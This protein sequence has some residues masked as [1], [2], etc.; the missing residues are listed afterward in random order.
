MPEGEQKSIAEDALSA[1]EGVASKT[2]RALDTVSDEGDSGL[3]LSDLITGRPKAE[4]STFQRYVLDPLDMPQKWLVRKPL[5]AIAGLPEGS[6]ETLTTFN[7]ALDRPQGRGAVLLGKLRGD[8]ATPFTAPLKAIGKAVEAVTGERPEAID[9]LSQEIEHQVTGLA[10]PLMLV[11]GSSGPKTALAVSER[12]LRSTPVASKATA[13]RE[14]AQAISSPKGLAGPLEASWRGVKKALVKAG[15]PISDIEKAFGQRGEFFGRGQLTIADKEI[16]PALGLGEFAGGKLAQK[17]FSKL[18][19]TGAYGRLA[20]RVAIP[21]EPLYQALKRRADTKAILST[22]R[23]TAERARR[24]GMATA[25]AAAKQGLL[26]PNAV[27]DIVANI[28]DNSQRKGFA[29][30]QARLKQT[31]T[32]RGG[33]LPQ[34]VDQ[35]LHATWQQYT[36]ALESVARRRATGG[37]KPIGQAAAD[38]ATKAI[39]WV[40]SKWKKNILANTPGYHVVNTWGDSHM[41]FVNG[42]NPLGIVEADRLLARAKGGDWK[43][44][45]ELMEANRYGIGGVQPPGVRLERLGGHSR[46]RDERALEIVGGRATTGEKASGAIDKVRGVLPQ[47]LPIGETYSDWW[48]SVSKLA[49]YIDGKK[50]GLSSELAAKRAFDI[51]ID[52][53]EPVTFGGKDI[54]WVKRF[55]PFYNYI[56]KSPVAAVRGLVT[57]PGRFVLAGRAAATANEG[58]STEDVPTWAKE[59]GTPLE[60]QQLASAMEKASHILGGPAIGTPVFASPRVGAYEALATPVNLAGHALSGEGREALLGVARQLGPV[61][62][63]VLETISGTDILTGQPKPSRSGVETAIG[64]I[65]APVLVPRPLLEAGNIAIQR[66]GGPDQALG[67]YDPVSPI[68]EHRQIARAISVLTGIN[69]QVTSP[70]GRLS[71]ALSSSDTRALIKA[72]EEAAKQSRERERRRERRE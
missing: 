2:R 26:S 47:T 57:K 50:K 17:L 54:T 4:K 22:S 64:E 68:P 60:V 34:A 59:A 12:L 39:D 20:G 35:A 29:E 24:E 15:V 46:H 25:E 14:I 18:Q 19:H 6:G 5:E 51:L 27:Q 16:A 38:A 7:A 9:N 61:T 62:K 23:A 11:G 45:A 8:I 72:A 36:K 30:A 3:E 58:A 31:F 69:P 43:A 44:R 42:V 49:V 56:T 66:A 32:P 53:G 40:Q 52:F 71:N 67:R 63:P 37:V 55:L 21:A 48:E 41:M 1:M 10:D 65:I 33:P 13:L 28:H 70:V